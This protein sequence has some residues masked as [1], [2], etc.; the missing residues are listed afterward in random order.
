MNQKLCECDCGQ[1]VKPGRRFINGHNQKGKKH[2]D[3]TREKISQG[4]IG[5]YHTDETKEK[6][7]LAKLGKTLSEETKLKM[8]RAKLG[9]KHSEE[10][11]EKIRQAYHSDSIVRHHLIYDHNDLSKFIVPMTR[12]AHAILHAVYRKAG[13]KVPHI[14]EE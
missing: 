14:N 6:I 7:S 10:S 13:Y 1:K 4:N 9:Y 11:K 3:E 2:S 12:S 8:S 5:K